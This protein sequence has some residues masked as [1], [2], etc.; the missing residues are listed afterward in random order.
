MERHSVIRDELITIL[1]GALVLVVLYLTS[2]Y[3]YLLFHSLAEVFSTVIAFSI[4]VLAWNSRQFLDNNYLLLM[5]IAYLFIGGLHLLHTLAYK[6]MGVFQGYDAN[7]PTQLWIVA[8]YVEGLSFLIAPLFLRRKLKANL[9]FLGYAIV[10]ALLLGLIFGRSFP[11]CYVEGVGLTLFKKVS[12]YIISVIL[13]ASVYVLLRNRTE[14]APDVLRWLVWS[15]VATIGAELAF[16]LYTSVYGF[17]NLMGHQA[18]LQAIRNT[19][20]C[21]LSGTCDSRHIEQR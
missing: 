14:F 21:L 1:A 12:E 2:L 19:P 17:S 4:F 3:S 5:G 20:T 18:S 13:L 16:T 6:G 7:L 11:D 10:F 9:A 15:I 8:R